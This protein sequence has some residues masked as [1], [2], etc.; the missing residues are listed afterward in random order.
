MPIYAIGARMSDE[1]V[2]DLFLEHNVVGSDWDPTGTGVHAQFRNLRIGDLVFLK[3]A[4]PG[5]P[6]T[7]LG[8]GVISTER[9]HKTFQQYRGTFRDVLWLWQGDAF[10]INPSHGLG[11][12]RFNTI[13]QEPDPVVTQIVIAALRSR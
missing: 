11:Q 2:T 7:V 12:M 8:I 4:A 6:L 13:F 5:H 10:D 3:R 1:D 9:V